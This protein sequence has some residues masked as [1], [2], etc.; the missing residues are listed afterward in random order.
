M[1]DGMNKIHM[2]ERETE[3]IHTPAKKKSKTTNKGEYH[4]TIYKHRNTSICEEKKA[5]SSVVH[6]TLDLGEE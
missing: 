1:K 4:I 2:G 6:S 5:E 3:V